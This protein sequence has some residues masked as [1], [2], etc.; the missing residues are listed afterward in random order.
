[1][2]PDGK[3]FACQSQDNQILL[4][5]THR[6]FKLHKRKRFL[7]HHNAGY[8]AQINFSP[9]GKIICSGDGNGRCFFWD[10]KT[11]KVR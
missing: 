2:H 1:M 7:G 4:Y 6:G 11:S 10:W 5:S 3:W 8:A 9:D